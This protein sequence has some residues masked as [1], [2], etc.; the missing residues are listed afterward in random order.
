MG[1]CTPA[2]KGDRSWNYQEDGSA[3][4][5]SSKTLFAGSQNHTT[6]VGIPLGSEMK[7]V[8]RP[9]FS[10]MLNSGETESGQYPWRECTDLA[11]WRTMRN[12]ILKIVLKRMAF[13]FTEKFLRLFI[14][15]M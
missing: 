10:L 5:T 4:N 11:H 7:L 15:L 1:E 12:S 14:I 13:L 9:L 6:G 2:C 8:M 3:D